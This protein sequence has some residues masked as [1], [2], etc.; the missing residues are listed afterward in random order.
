MK[1]GGK[2]MDEE[3]SFSELVNYKQVKC[4]VF[5]NVIDQGLN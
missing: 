2:F 5:K 4:N 3:C 1:L